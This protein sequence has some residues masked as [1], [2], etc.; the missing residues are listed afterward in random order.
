MVTSFLCIILGVLMVE[1]DGLLRLHVYRRMGVGS[2][3]LVQEVFHGRGLLVGLVQRHI[4]V[5]QDVH[6]DGVVAT[7]ATGAQ[8]VR[9]VD[10][11]QG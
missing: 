3:V 8:I 10:A 4:A 7:D 11:G 9:L 1:G 5:H 6:L 2:V